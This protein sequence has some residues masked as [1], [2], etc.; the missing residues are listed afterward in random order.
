MQLLLRAVVSIMGRGRYKA[1]VPN[2]ARS[3]FVPPANG[4]ATDK[5]VKASKKAADAAAAQD[6]A[7]VD[8][9]KSRTVVST[10]A[11]IGATEHFPAADS[12]SGAIT[13]TLP[14]TSDVAVG[15]IFLIKDEGGSAATNAITINTTGD[16][17]IDG[18]SS[19]SLV[20]DHAS[21]S[22]YYNGTNWS[23]Y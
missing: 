5:F 20:S 9:A 22:V 18:N 15:K 2:S 19:I 6:T 16:V 21:I 17:T 13:L 23:I 7:A 11:T 14:D 8:K 10:S 1:F 3:S 12:S 4:N